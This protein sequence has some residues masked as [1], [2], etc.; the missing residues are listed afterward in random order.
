M[1]LH[2]LNILLVAPSLVLMA[3]LKKELGG[4]GIV[5]TACCQTVADAM[6]AMRMKKPDLVLSSMYFSDG[7]G[8]ALISEMRQD[9]ELK[10]TLFMLVSSET[11]FEML[12][13]IRQAGVVAILP[14]PFTQEAFEHAMHL[15]CGYLDEK[16]WAID[17][18]HISSLKLLLVDDSRLARRHML[19]ILQK[20]GVDASKVTQAEN[21]AE[22][23]E[24]LQDEKFD[25]VL[26]DY[27]MPKM[28]GEELLKY[29][30]QDSGLDKMSVIM[31]TSE[32]NEATLASIQS[33]GVTALL[34]KPFTP[35]YL[36]IVFEKHLK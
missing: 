5:H 15:A 7:D 3:S 16:P 19:T 4:M 10:D 22:A 9:V 13:P 1:Q 31:V 29:I 14:R 28:D 6:H 24:K 20:L 26:T 21:G 12:D 2:Q 33:H 25:M 32:Q 17:S 27:N 23:I 11:R 8:I 34:D 30:R 18:V 35:D 36:R